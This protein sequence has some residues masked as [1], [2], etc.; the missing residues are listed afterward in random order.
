MMVAEPKNSLIGEAK[1][2]RCITLVI[3]FENLSV[4]F[5]NFVSNIFSALKPFII[6][7]PPS[8]S[9]RK[10]IKLPVSSWAKADF[11]LSFFEIDEIINPDTGNKINTNKVNF[12]LIANI[13]AKV[14]TMVNG[15]LTKVSSE[16][17]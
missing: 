12:A 11:A 14:N 10:E 7:R 13:D 1:V 17:R 15:S 3:S 4:E 6:L 16:F 5:V 2:F 9:S 8:V